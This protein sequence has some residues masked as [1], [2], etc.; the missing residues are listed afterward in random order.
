MAATV[1][2]A[3]VVDVAV[4]MVGPVVTAVEKLGLWGD[5]MTYQVALVE[6]MV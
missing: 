4:E 6:V 5:L 2:A 1:V 3:M